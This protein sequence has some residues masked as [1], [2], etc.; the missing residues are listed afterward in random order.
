[1][2]TSIQ[3][4]GILTFHYAHNYG[5][6]LQ[7]YALKTYLT[8]QGFEVH[9]INYRS[10]EV[11]YPYREQFALWELVG[12]RGLVFPWRWP[13]TLRKCRRICARMNAWRER[14]GAFINFEETYLLDHDPA[15]VSLEEV[16]RMDL[17]AL[18]FG[19]D[20][21]WNTAIV[22]ERE[23]VYWGD[24]QTRGRKIAYGASSL[25]KVLTPLERERIAQCVKSFYAVSVREEALAQWT[26]EIT[27][28][29][30]PVVVD[31][32]LL[33]HGEEYEALMPPAGPEER[34]YI[35]L[36]L[37]RKGEEAAR[38][39]RKAGEALGLPVKTVGCR[40]GVELISYDEGFERE[41]E[42]GP[43]QFLGLVRRAAYVITTSFHG[44]VFSILFRRP[45]CSVYET[46]IRMDYLLSMTGLERAHIPN[47]QAFSSDSFVRATQEN[48]EQLRPAIEASRSYL[49]AALQ[50]EKPHG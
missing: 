42:A 23:R 14:K 28:R 7:A 16:E 17:D 5:A 18:V 45:F 13:D 33:L 38:A 50:G 4:I 19:S 24:F 43:A 21:I 30:V 48:L 15:P 25:T 41:L 29:R 9:I 11:I 34:P 6:M 20:Q 26:E 32:A 37:I 46:D 44:T 35:L 3:K 49:A 27:G 2:E 36:Y 40:G 8:Q 12:R 39:A 47:A 1:M 22:G 10:E 31:P